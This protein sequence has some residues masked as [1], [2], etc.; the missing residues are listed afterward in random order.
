M[1][2]PILLACKRRSTADASQAMAGTAANEDQGT[3]QW[4]A[5]ESARKSA[6]P[7]KKTPR[8]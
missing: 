1:T 6:T 3:K 7:A 4:G 5:A 8:R 2:P